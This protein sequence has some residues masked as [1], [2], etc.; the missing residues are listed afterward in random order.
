MYTKKDKKAWISANRIYRWHVE[1]FENEIDR[2][3]KVIG[4][5]FDLVVE[6][7]EP[8]DELDDIELIEMKNP[9]FNI[10]DV[11]CK[12]IPNMPDDDDRYERFSKLACPLE[13]RF[14][15]MSDEEIKQEILE[16]EGDLD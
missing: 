13:L 11:Q 16:A 2:V 7:W 14:I 6:H 10:G 4:S 9:I 3:L 15:Y 8:Y 1:K 5:C 12:D